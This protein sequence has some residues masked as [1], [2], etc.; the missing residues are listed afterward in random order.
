ML[1]VNNNDEEKLKV[2]QQKASASEPENV[3][4]YNMA[5]LETLPPNT[6][7]DDVV[8]KIKEWTDKINSIK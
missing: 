8:Q 7:D 2:L 6:T 4:G 5:L 3:D 1:A